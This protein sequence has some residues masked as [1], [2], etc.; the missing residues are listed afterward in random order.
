MKRSKIFRIIKTYWLDFIKFCFGSFPMKEEIEKNDKRSY[1]D[2]HAF[3]IIIVG[4][5]VLFVIVVLLMFSGV[6]V[7]TT[8][9]AFNG[10]AGPFISLLGA[11][12]VYRSFMAQVK[13]NEQ[14]QLSNLEQ[15][16]ANR[17]IDSQWSFDTYLRLL[18]EATDRFEEIKISHVV[19]YGDKVADN[20]YYGREAFEKIIQKNWSEIL[21]AKKAYTD[22][23]IVLEE[24][25]YL[26]S[27]ISKTPFTQKHYIAYKILRFH[28]NNLENL[29]DEL[30]ARF[31]ETSTPKNYQFTNDYFNI[32]YDRLTELHKE[33]FPE[34]ENISDI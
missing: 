4:A 29:N 14:Q 11:I 18:R 32:L 3:E 19:S 16:K 27:I 2:R 33:V 5:I 28:K 24:L 21:G 25:V 31:K 23:A 12:L 34:K 26:I 9:D 13:S 30:L 10:V 6:I 1:F 8:G 15:Q 22:L 17:M 7:G 20:Q